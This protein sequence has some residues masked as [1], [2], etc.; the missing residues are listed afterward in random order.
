VGL[1]TSSLSGDGKLYGCGTNNSGELGLNSV[2]ECA[3][4]LTEFF[5]ALSEIPVADFTSSSSPRTDPCTQPDGTT[6]DANIFRLTFVMGNVESVAT[7]SAHA[8]STKDG[9]LWTWGSNE[10]SPLGL[11]LA[12]QNR[13]LKVERVPLV[14]SF[15]CGGNCSHVVDLQGHICSGR[16]FTSGFSWGRSFS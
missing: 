14:S 10:N 5:S 12:Q 6:K 8:L 15:G 9:T 4:I 11:E 3:K 1:T 13:P 7:G 16:W 2:F